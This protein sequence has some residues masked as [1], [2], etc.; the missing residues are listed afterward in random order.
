M[1]VCSVSVIVVVVDDIIIVVAVA[2]AKLQMLYTVCIL[3]PYLALKKTMNCKV[4]QF[5]FTHPCP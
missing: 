2:Y 5:Q 4:F 3:L 1:F